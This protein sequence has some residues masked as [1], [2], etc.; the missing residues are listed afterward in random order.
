MNNTGWTVARLIACSVQVGKPGR[1]GK[2]GTATFS[3]K[4]GMN[5]ASET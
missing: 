4:V 5:D 1:P 3:E 2:G